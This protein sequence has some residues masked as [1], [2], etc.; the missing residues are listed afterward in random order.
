MSLWR[1]CKC[2]CTSFI[3]D[4]NS[5]RGFDE[6]FFMHRRGLRKALVVL[7]PQNAPLL[8]RTVRGSVEAACPEKSL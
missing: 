3:S 8:L 1:P 4:T 6:A 7:S 5:C 2:F